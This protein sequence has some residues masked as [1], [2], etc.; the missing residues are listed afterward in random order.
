MKKLITL[1]IITLFLMS[2]LVL[3]TPP[4]PQHIRGYFNVNGVSLPGH[5]IEV[6]NMYTGETISGDNYPSL[7]TEVNGFA[8]DLSYFKEGVEGRSRYSPGDQIKVQARRFGEEEAIYFNVPEETPYEI[9]LEISTGLPTLYCPDG[10]PVLDLANCPVVEPESAPVEPVIIKKVICED[11]TEVSEA[12]ECPIV[13][14]EEKDT[15]QTILITL[16]AAIIG[17]FAWGK[18]FAGLIKYYLR[19]AKET[20]D[21]E[22]A[23][24]YRAR[25]EK[26]AKTTVTNF[27]AG[28]YKK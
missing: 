2:L 26:M 9:T 16:I 14:P 12:S 17:L 27:L 4:I 24:K 1:S 20:D 23:K 15:L 3:A 25:A 19:L 18:G 6:T 22:L 11:G 21:K 28:K 8:F 5:I 7:V 10:T 13:E